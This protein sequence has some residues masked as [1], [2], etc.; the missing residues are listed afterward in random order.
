MEIEPRSEREPAP[1][2]EADREN[3]VELLQGAAADGRLPLEDLSDRVGMVLTADTREQLDS[4]TAG[5]ETAPQVGSARTVSTIVTLLGDRRQVGRW[6][7]PRTLRAVALAGDIHLD[8]RGVVV[9]DEVVD[10]SA[11]A[12]LGNFCVDVPDGVEVELTGFD[13][14]GDRE[15]RLPAVPRRAG[16]P[17][18]RVRAYGLLGDV[19]VRTPEEGEEPPSW[20][21]W[22]RGSRRGRR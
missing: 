5:L 15:L 8:L 3:A 16:T 22:F 12:L 11:V 21:A 14:L 7:L 4:A 18:I 6:R 17:L 9:S 19:D 13:L 20:W 10:I 1:I 2:T